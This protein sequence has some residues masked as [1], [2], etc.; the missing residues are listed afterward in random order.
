[1]VLKEGAEE[2]AAWGGG[3]FELLVEIDS[4]SHPSRVTGVSE[5]MRKE[6]QKRRSPQEQARGQV[7]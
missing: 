7:K 4:K 1:L 2:I 5:T 6:R 3:E